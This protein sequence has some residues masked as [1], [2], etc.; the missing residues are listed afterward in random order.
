MIESQVTI[1]SPY[2]GYPILYL[3]YS[4]GQKPRVSLAMYSLG[5]MGWILGFGDLQRVEGGGPD[6]PWRSKSGS[7]GGY[8][9]RNLGP[10]LPYTPWGAWVGSRC[11]GVRESAVGWGWGG[12]DHPRRSRSG[13]RGCWSCSGWWAT[14]SIKKK[15]KC[16]RTFR[17]R[18]D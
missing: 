18:Y 2:Q 17:K 8:W 15:Q 13:S 14:G 1:Q 12:S 4:K 7:R 11:S 3:Q 16:E 6:H 5:S 9:F 10:S